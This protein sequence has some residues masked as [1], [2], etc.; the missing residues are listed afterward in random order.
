MK[1]KKVATLKAFLKNIDGSSN[2][3]EKTPEKQM[4]FKERDQ[5]LEITQIMEYHQGTASRQPNN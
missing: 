1:N 3:L 2:Q 5:F 4:V